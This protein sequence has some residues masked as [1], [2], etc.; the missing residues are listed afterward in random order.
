M[1]V[2]GGGGLGGWAG[3]AGGGSLSAPVVKEYH[4]TMYMG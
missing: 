4:V 3:W 1:S 2:F